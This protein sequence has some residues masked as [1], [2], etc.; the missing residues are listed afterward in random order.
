ARR[1]QLLVRDAN[2]DVRRIRLF[3]IRHQRLGADR[4]DDAQGTRPP[5][6][7]RAEPSGQPHVRDA[8]GVVGVI[9]REQQRI[10]AAERHAELIEPYRGAASGVDEQRLVAGL[11]QRA[12]SETFGTRSGHSGPEQRHAEIAGHGCIVI[13]E[14]FTTLLQWASSATRNR[15][16]SVGVPPAGSAAIFSIASRTR[17]FARALLAAWFSRATTSSGVP[18]FTSRPN[19]SWMINSGK[20][21]SPTVGTSLRAGSR[22]GP[23]TASARSLPVAIR[24]MTGSGVMN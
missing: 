14:S 15:P 2:L 22:A 23:V 18:R 16:K 4:A 3:E 10:D 13:P 24:S 7:V 11:D 12:R 8:G 9:V 17:G 19:Q 1:R 20:P 5:R 6:V 21:A